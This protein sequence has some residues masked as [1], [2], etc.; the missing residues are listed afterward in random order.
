MLCLKIEKHSI[1][2][3]SN[4]LFKKILML[5]LKHNNIF[6]KKKVKLSLKR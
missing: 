2:K 1:K 3:E 6:L 4:T 5:S